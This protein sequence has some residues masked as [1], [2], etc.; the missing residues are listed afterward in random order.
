MTAVD[1]AGSAAEGAD[2]DRA[3]LDA[4]GGLFCERLQYDFLFRWFLDLPGVGTASDATP[5]TKNR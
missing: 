5:F 1:T 4:V 2:S 3:V